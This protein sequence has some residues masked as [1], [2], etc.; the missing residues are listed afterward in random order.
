[1]KVYNLEGIVL[2]TKVFRNRKQRALFQIRWKNSLKKMNQK[3]ID[4]VNNI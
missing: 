1:M 3:W 4:L 2:K